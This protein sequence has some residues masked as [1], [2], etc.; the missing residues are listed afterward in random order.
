ME[1]KIGNSGLVQ[2]LYFFEGNDILGISKE[3][4]EYVNENKLFNGKRGEIFSN[5][6]P[7][8][9]NIILLGLGKESEVS[10]ENIRRAFLSLGKCLKANKVKSCNIEIKNLMDFVTN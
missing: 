1:F 2:V 5:L 10:L 6:G 8:T 4:K 9:E 7:N 3:L